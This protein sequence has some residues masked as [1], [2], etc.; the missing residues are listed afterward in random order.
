[1]AAL[2]NLED[3][4]M[5]DYL[6]VYGFPADLSPYSD[7]KDAVLGDRLPAFLLLFVPS[8][9][10]RTWTC[11]AARFLPSLRFGASHEIASTQPGARQ[12]ERVADD[13]RRLSSLEEADLAHNALSGLPDS[14]GELKSMRLLNLGTTF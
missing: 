7:S 10:W 5:G 6:S 2:V 8:Q 14:F 13:D 3:F 11:G 4:V 12:T 1:M 9:V